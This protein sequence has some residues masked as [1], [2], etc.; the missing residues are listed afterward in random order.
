[1]FEASY[2]SVILAFGFEKTWRQLYVWCE[3][4]IVL[5]CPFRKW[6][7]IPFD[8]SNTTMGDSCILYK[9]S[10]VPRRDLTSYHQFCP[11]NSSLLQL[12]FIDHPRPGNAIN[13]CP[14]CHRS[15]LNVMP[16]MGLRS[17]EKL[18]YPWGDLWQERTVHLSVW[19]LSP[20]PRKILLAFPLS[21]AMHISGRLKG[22]SL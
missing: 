18:Y 14:G 6:L 11:S 15:K 16:K 17:S 9:S 13:L 22:R 1:M 3:T 7:V 10:P 4:F 5:H 2:T 20:M 21:Y 19:S 8:I 12:N